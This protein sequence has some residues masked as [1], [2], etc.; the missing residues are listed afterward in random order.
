MLNKAHT[1]MTPARKARVRTFSRTALP[2]FAVGAAL[3]AAGVYGAWRVHRLH[4]RG[5]DMLSDNVASIRAAEKF[6]MIVREVRHRLKRHN[7][8]GAERHLQ[9][10]AELLTRGGEALD[11]AQAL[12]ATTRE[13]RIV[14]QMREGYERLADSF[15]SIA[16]E[17][18]SLV[19]HEAYANLADNV[20]PE[21][22]LPPTDRYIEVNETSLDRS[23]QRN[24]SKANQ[25]MFGLL[26]LGTCGGVAGL[27]AG[28]GIA[29]LVNRTIVQLAI[30]IRDTAGQLSQVA[31]PVTW[32]AEPGFDDLESILRSVSEHVSTVVRRL[33]ESE[34]ERL[35]AEQ[36]AAVGQLAAGLAHELRN[37]LTSMKAI[38][39]LAPTPGDM[40]PRDLE[41]LRE[42]AE[43]LEHSVQS[44]LDYARPPQPRKGETDLGRML[45]QLASLVRRRV[46]RK[47]VSL[48]YWA[49]QTE[50]VMHA[51]EG[52]LRQVVLNLLMNAIDVT[53]RG[54]SILLWCDADVA[55]AAPG[56]P[57]DGA[58]SGW[59][60]IRVSDTGPGL[61]RE[62]G[63]RMFE[64]FITTKDTG[65]GLGLS[66]CQRIVRHHGGTITAR[67]RTGGGAVLE[68]RLPVYPAPRTPRQPREA[69]AD[70]HA[71]VAA[72]AGRDAKEDR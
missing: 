15:A 63:E 70:K 11:E 45:E 50:V 38:L 61:P 6:E 9:D 55:P 53:P 62:L 33:Q 10:V 71:S 26:M 21:R 18:A 1:A 39:Q 3:L 20:I 54:G 69:I 56:A 29:R 17:P 49:P 35:R 22:V 34:H 41:V 25:L 19:R 16:D 28:Y 48:T 59:A 47:G 43:R 64:P 2:I 32:T 8:S 42:E 52:Q 13:Q 36:L 7:S 68:V 51:D 58:A 4:K 37:P 14:R 12:G 24:Q 67:N 30:P 5:G 27:I 31:G 60:V 66:I 23:R 44:L 46:E 57:H 65:T 72:A 40:T